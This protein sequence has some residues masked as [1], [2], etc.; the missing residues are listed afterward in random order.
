M[1]PKRIPP[2]ISDHVGEIVKLL[3]RNTAYGHRP[4]AV[5][6]D[7]LD[8][9]HASLQA[10]PVHMRNALAGKPLPED[11]PEAQAL[12][13]RLRSRYPRPQAWEHFA[14]AF[15][16]LLDGTDGYWQDL[17][18][19]GGSGGYDVLGSVYM[20]LCANPHSGQFFTPW[21]VAA[22]M[23]EVTVQDGEAEVFERLRQAARA[24]CKRD[25]VNAQVL[26]AA[27]IAGT[28]L[29]QDQPELHAEHFAR[30]VL[31]RIA[32]DLEPITICDPCCGS[33]IMF[34]A[35]VRRFPAWAVQAGIVQF[36]GMD[37]DATCVRM[38]QT[39]LM[40]YGIH[41]GEL[42]SAL[43]ASESQL[44]ALPQPYAQAYTLAQEAQE[45]GETDQV[46]EIARAVRQQQMLF[47]PQEFA[48]QARTVRPPARSQKPALVA[49]D[50]TTDLF[51]LISS[52]P[53]EVS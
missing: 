4:S 37:I 32:G 2:P 38:A 5:F 30:Q 52:S 46:T 10:L 1:K 51:A 12:F 26:S 6:T 49:D 28:V 13:A 27:I 43:T 33:G 15:A 19:P 8:A 41:A 16:V 22:F 11:T 42:L 47:D 39:N 24:A 23:A 44:A 21:H 48:V 31:P 7:W 36:Y 34:L 20:E 40:L 17:P 25:D 18:A 9:V 53:A 35:A 14:Q 50:L 45:R 29:P 3:E